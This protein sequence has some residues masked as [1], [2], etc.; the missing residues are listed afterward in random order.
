[1]NDEKPKNVDEYK[2]WL[3]EKHGVEVS[4]REEAYYKNVTMRIVAEL[5]K[6]VFW[7]QLVK[8][9][10]EYH[11]EYQLNTGYPLLMAREYQPKVESKPFDSFLLKTYRKNILNNKH[12]PDAPQGGWVLPSNWYSKTN[13]VVRTLLEVKYLDGV[14]FL[15]GKIKHFCE[16]YNTVCKASLEAR[17]EGY[18]AAHLYVEQNFEIPK[19]NWDTERIDIPVEIQITTQLQEVIRKL[20][21]KYYEDKRQSTGSK[22]SETKKWQW[23]YKSDEFSAAYLGHIL[24]YVEGMITEI[25]ERQK[26]KETIR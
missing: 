13:D 22:E 10:P 9:L 2:R 6:S 26:K 16:G 11:D 17:E 12:W 3:K 14:E 4:S 23:D 1:M 7:V 25:R 24:H 15:I 8:S 5:Q 20:L 21:H 18:Y 19:A